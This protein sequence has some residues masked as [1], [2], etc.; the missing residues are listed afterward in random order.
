M[1]QGRCYSTDCLEPIL[2]KGFSQGEE[3]K[4]KLEGPQ[5]FELSFP[6]LYRAAAWVQEEISF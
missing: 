1:P 4:L 6:G 3:E 2:G 5:W